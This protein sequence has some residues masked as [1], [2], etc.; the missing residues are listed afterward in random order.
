MTKKG[1]DLGDCMPYL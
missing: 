1:F